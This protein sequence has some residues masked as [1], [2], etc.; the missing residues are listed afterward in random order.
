MYIAINNCDP[1]FTNK[2][3][4][5]FVARSAFVIKKCRRLI[6]TVNQVSMVLM[7]SG[8]GCMQGVQGSNPLMTSKKIRSIFLK[9]GLPL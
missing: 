7:V 9:F 3:R 5:M 1:L 2:W 6:P 4:P 8:D